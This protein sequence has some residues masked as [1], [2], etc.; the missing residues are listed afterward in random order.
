MA[1]HAGRGLL[2]VSL[3]VPLGIDDREPGA[4]FLPVLLEECLQVR[5]TIPIEIVE[6]TEVKSAADVFQIVSQCVHVMS[7]DC[8]EGKQEEHDGQ[9]NKEDDIA[10]KDLEKYGL[11]HASSLYPTPRIFLIRSAASGP[12]FS[13]RFR[14]WTS[15]VRS[16]TIF[17]CPQ[18]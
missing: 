14:M 5:E 12:S 9:Q 18:R 2:R 16:R 7:L 17:S 10:S 4:D 6:D 3:D 11:F 15:T 1:F 8:A 13:L